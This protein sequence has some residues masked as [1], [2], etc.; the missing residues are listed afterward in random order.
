MVTI[1]HKTGLVEHAANLD[2][3]ALFAIR[4]KESCTIE[5][6]ARVPDDKRARVLVFEDGVLV[7]G[8]VDEDTRE[9]WAYRLENW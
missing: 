5:L 6:K 8:E 2:T 1:T 7:S 4:L 3:G 9:Y